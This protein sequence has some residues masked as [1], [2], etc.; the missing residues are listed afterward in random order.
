MVPIYCFSIPEGDITIGQLELPS[1]KPEAEVGQIWK[2]GLSYV[3]Q[4]VNI[5]NDCIL[6]A[7]VE[8]HEDRPMVGDHLVFVQEELDNDELFCLIS[9]GAEE[10]EAVSCQKCGVENKWA[11]ANPFDGSYICWE[12]Q[13]IG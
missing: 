1:K 3:A 12:C 7:V 5:V 9:S 8:A 11:E 4:V 6:F 10:A 13:N 2:Y